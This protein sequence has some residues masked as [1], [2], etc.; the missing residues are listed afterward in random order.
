M[1]DSQFKDFIQFVLDALLDAQSEKD[2]RVR[3]AKTQKVID[4]LQKVLKN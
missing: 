1:T 2:Q 3:D 4:N